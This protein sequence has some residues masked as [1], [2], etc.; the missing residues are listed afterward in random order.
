[1]SLISVCCFFFLL[2]RS[3]FSLIPSNSKLKTQ[4]ALSCRFVLA[5]A[6]T[7]YHSLGQEVL[8]R[9]ARGLGDA[10][11]LNCF[12]SS[13]LGIPLALFFFFFRLLS[14]FCDFFFFLSFSL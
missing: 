2:L 13:G 3:T 14:Y 1:M 12:F 5:E 8:R 6:C 10:G 7:W 4:Q 11:E 9:E